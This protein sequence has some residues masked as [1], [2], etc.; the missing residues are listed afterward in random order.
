MHLQP[1]MGIPGIP[2]STTA[3]FFG[4]IDAKRVLSSR[5]KRQRPGETRRFFFKFIYTRRGTESELR[6]SKFDS[7]PFSWMETEQPPSLFS[8]FSRFA[9]ESTPFLFFSSGGMRRRGRHFPYV[10]K[11]RGNGVHTAQLRDL[12]RNHE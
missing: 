9:T 3:T 7:P 6:I 5:Y 8:F 2:R 12:L 11:S 10:S 4:T 1:N